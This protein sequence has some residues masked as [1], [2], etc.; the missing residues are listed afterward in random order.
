[1]LLRYKSNSKIRSV[2]IVLN[3]F[4]CS[5]C[6]Q[7]KKHILDIISLTFNNMSVLQ[8]LNIASYSHTKYLTVIYVSM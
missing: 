2:K 6:L 8:K 1:M 4:N 5:D 3:S 7:F